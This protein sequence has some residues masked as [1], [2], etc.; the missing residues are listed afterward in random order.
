MIPGAQVGFQCLSFDYGMRKLPML[1]INFDAFDASSGGSC[2][3]PRSTHLQPNRPHRN[4]RAFGKALRSGLPRSVP[5][6]TTPILPYFTSTPPE[7]VWLSSKELKKEDIR[8]PACEKDE[9]S[10][11]GDKDPYTQWA[12]G[13]YIVG[14]DN[15]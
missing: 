1:L 13:E 15:T 12:H 10:D 5:V 3:R 7:G 9:S 8:R 6:I 4:P 14:T 11:T 2:F